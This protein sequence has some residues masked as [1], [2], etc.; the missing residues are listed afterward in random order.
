MAMQNRSSSYV[1]GVLT[2]VMVM[3]LFQFL[4]GNKI[5][6][7]RL[8]TL[9][10][11]VL[12]LVLLLFLFR[13]NFRSIMDIFLLK[14]GGQGVSGSTRSAVA[15]LHFRVFLEN[16]LFGVG[17][18]TLRSADL[19]TG[20]LAQGGIIGISLYLGA[21]GSLCIRLLRQGTTEAKDLVIMIVS[22]NVIM[23]ISVPEFMQIH[24][25]VYYAMGQFLIIQ[26]HKKGM[27]RTI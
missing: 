7:K 8:K 4:Y 5:Q 15:A 2:A 14:I 12:V 23:M 19:I 9:C 17:F 20:W 11:V 18:G 6:K 21:V 3:V 16:F 24:I 26:N 25:W 22:Y 1:L 13:D 27:R 10:F